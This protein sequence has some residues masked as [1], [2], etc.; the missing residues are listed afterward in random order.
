MEE[1]IKDYYSLGLQ[2]ADKPLTEEEITQ[3]KDEFRQQ[4]HYYRDQEPWKVWTRNTCSQ[5]VWKD[6]EV[7]KKLDMT[8]LRILMDLDLREKDHLNKGFTIVTREMVLDEIKKF[9]QYL[10]A[11]QQYVIL[12]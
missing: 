4:L 8:E 12:A 5:S 2:S 11:I 10:P 3:L 1:N 9:G 6:S 7:N